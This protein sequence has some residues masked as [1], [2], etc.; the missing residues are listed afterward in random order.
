M[1]LLPTLPLSVGIPAQASNSVGV[2][3]WGVG[4]APGLGAS[5]MLK[6]LLIVVQ[7]K[8]EGKSIP[9]TTPVFVIGRAEECHLKPNSDEVSRRHTEITV[10]DTSV[11]VRDLGSRNGTRV[12]GKLLKE[13]HTLKSGELLQVGPL[14]FAVAIPELSG[15]GT[16]ST[17]APSNAPAAAS[18]AIEDV[19]HHQID[20]W[21]VSDNSHPIPDRPSGVYDGETITIDSYQGEGGSKSKPSPSDADSEQVASPYEAALENYERPPEG[22]GDA[23]TVD[24]A[25]G[26]DDDG[27]DDDEDRRDDQDDQDEFMDES[28]PFHKKKAP[29]VAD[30]PKASAPKYTD[31]SSAADDILKRMLDRRRTTRP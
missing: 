14:T 26:D 6:V 10:S 27:D 23:E 7:G 24:S 1:D 5:N 17:P 28:N 4:A 25:A 18:G 16:V 19:S 29:E 9:V 3:P 21:L 15:R 31:T 12:N 11:S 8:P 2:A 22:D 20:A 30:A 13:P